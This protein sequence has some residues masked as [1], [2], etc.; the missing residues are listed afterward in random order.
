MGTL[1]GVNSC[2]FSILPTYLVT[3]GQILFITLLWVEEEEEVSLLLTSPY[4]IIYLHLYNYNYS[5]IPLIQA[6]QFYNRFL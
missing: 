1:N 3:L 6:S 5:I 2:I 4:S